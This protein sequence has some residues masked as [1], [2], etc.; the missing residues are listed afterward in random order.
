MTTLAAV[1]GALPIAMGMGADGASRKPLGMVIVG[2]L[3]V[4]QFITLYITP[5]IY[6]FLEDFQEKVLD[7]TTFFRSSRASHTPVPV[8]PNRTS[9]PALVGGNGGNGH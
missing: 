1:A 6:L 9:E 5:V 3:I 2:G 7:R 4:S 8:L